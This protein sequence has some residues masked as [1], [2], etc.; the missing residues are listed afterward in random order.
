MVTKESIALHAI[1]SILILVSN[2][3]MSILIPV[4]N[5][6]VAILIL[7]SNWLILYMHIFH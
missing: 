1:M 6:P 5:W 3:P 4:S 2:W 7:A